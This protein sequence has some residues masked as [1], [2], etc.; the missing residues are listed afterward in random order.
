MAYEGYSRAQAIVLEMQNSLNYEVDEQLCKRMAGLY[1]FIYRRLVDA[2]TRRDL[3]AA[4]DALRILEFQRETWVMLIDKLKEE[5]DQDGNS[6]AD[7]SASPSIDVSDQEP[8]DLEQS[9][10]GSLSVEG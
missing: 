9:T 3:T 7:G 5:R 6:N 1:N 8:V 2:S 10:Y 4:Q